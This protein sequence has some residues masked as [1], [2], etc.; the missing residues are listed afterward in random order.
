MCVCCLAVRV[1]VC[2]WLCVCVRAHLIANMF[3]FGR[4]Y[5]RVRVIHTIVS[6][7]LQATGHH[8]VRDRRL[9]VRRGALRAQPQQ[10]DARSPHHPRRQHHPQHEDVR[11]FMSSLEIPVTS[12]THKIRACRF[13]FL[14]KLDL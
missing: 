11:R 12:K 10:V 2:V 4:M 1:V 7:S 5:V 13:H 8:R 9:H 3:V 6:V 14:C